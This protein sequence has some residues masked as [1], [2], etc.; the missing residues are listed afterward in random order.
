MR[1]QGS[2]VGRELETRQHTPAVPAVRYGL[3]NTCAFASMQRHASDAIYR[4]KYSWTRSRFRLFRHSLDRTQKEGRYRLRRRRT[5]CD[6]YS[7][8]ESATAATWCDLMK[9]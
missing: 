3:E 7:A 4:E 6:G 5:A 8:F 9:Q 2:M 1:G